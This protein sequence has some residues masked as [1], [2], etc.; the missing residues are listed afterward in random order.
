MTMLNS[1]D[2]KSTFSPKLI[3]AIWTT[4]DLLAIERAGKG[5]GEADKATMA[6]ARGGNNLACNRN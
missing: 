2:K 4:M 1:F 6:Q 3:A 5:Y